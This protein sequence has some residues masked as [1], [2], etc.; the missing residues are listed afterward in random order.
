LSI[1]LRGTQ[2]H[3]RR[4]RVTPSKE[5]TLDPKDQE[6][7]IR[8]RSATGKTTIEP[9]AA[10]ESA[11]RTPADKTAERKPLGRD[12]DANSG[13]D[14]RK[15]P[16]K[17]ES[18]DGSLSIIDPNQAALETPVLYGKTF[19]GSTAANATSTS[20][21]EPVPISPQKPVES[22]V[23]KRDPLSDLELSM[24]AEQKPPERAP[25][26]VALSRGVAYLQG[27]MIRLTGGV[28]VR[29]GEEIKIGDRRFTLRSGRRRRTWIF[30]AGGL[31]VSV[32]LALM[33]PLFGSGD[34]AA[35]IGI[36]ADQS[37]SRIVPGVSVYLKELNRTVQSNDRGFFIFNSLPT[38]S[39]VLRITTDGYK[40]QSQKITIAE[41]DP[42]AL[43][44]NLIPWVPEEPSSASTSP[45][46]SSKK[47]TEETKAHEET[48]AGSTLGGVR[49]KS[50]VTDP[51][52][53]ID[54]RLAGVGN[55]LYQD[56]QP[57]KHV[58]AVTKPGYYDWAKEVQ[59]KSGRV[60]TLDVTLSENNTTDPD[61]QTWK[62]FVALGNNQ[63]NAGEPS[64]ALNSYDQA[65]NLK[66][67]SPEALL[68]RG[69]AHSKMGDKAKA[70]SDFEKSAR[71]FQVEGDYRNA[72]LSYANLISLDD[73]DPD[74]YLARGICY[75]KLGEY[76]TSV[77]D[78]NKALE[79]R[80]KMFSSYLSLGQA[81]YGAGNYQRSIDSYT[82]ADKI[83]SD[84]QQVFIGLTKA[85]FAKG[86]KSKAKKSYKEF[87]KLS[88]YIYR[89]KL[90]DDPEWRAVLEGIGVQSQP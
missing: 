78:F 16:G 68:G 58:V 30:L 9:P 64:S 86:D 5:K 31:A 19:V 34:H 53:L 82:K 83:K 37:T 69:Y 61:V 81:Y 27:S 72:A 77:S 1:N 51:N 14:R 87:E 88:T 8:R 71:L 13:V 76:L 35:L 55:N 52:V 80:P 42:L 6:I 17:H 20:S 85:H 29:P 11:R 23:P 57:G 15:K 41:A 59:V 3:Q 45:A 7:L 4:K 54:D 25:Q 84:D 65:I 32:L 66:S 10:R 28:R 40:P 79:L 50:N 74:L 38:G 24:K 22:D 12:V 49:V 56:I 26:S 33:L 73:R 63:L 48:L 46:P 43:R 47:S 75:L 67:D 89:E 90:K 36:V 2:I 62:D 18:D 21:R 70:R 44:V 60:L 39:Y